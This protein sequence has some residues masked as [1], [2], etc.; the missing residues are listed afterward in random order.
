MRFVAGSARP[1]PAE[2]GANYL[3]WRLNGLPGP[4]GLSYDLEPLEPGLHPTNVVAVGDFLDRAGHSGQTIFPVPQ[5]RVIP[6]PCTPAPLDVYF[7]IDD[8]NCLLNA[9]LNEMPARQAIVIGVGRVLDELSLG[10]DR[11]A[12]IGFGDVAHT[13]QPV[14]TDRTAI[15]DAA[16]AISMLDNSARLD[17]AYDET[18]RQ[19]AANRRPGAKL[20][21]IA[22]T[23]GPMS[24]P[25]PLTEAKANALRLTEGALHYTIGV[26]DLAQ[27]ATLR[28]VAEPGGM[29]ELD[30]GGDVIGAYADLG[31]M[32]IQAV[33]V[34]PPAGT[35]TP[36]TQPGDPT[37]TPPGPTPTATPR[38]PLPILLPWTER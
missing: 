3:L 14:T 5:V 38:S 15:L 30:F 11:A 35:A 18:R 28:A 6:P 24:A 4:E 17:Y 26:G 19:V 21:T 7:L 29:R 22:I 37:A 36:G 33:S 20:V 16:R 25:L 9:F 12:V 1:A 31:A 10:R 32:A 8:S 23:D 34:C 13:Y 27:Y 2:V